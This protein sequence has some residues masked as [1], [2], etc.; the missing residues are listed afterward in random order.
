MYFCKKDSRIKNG[1]LS[2]MEEK[3]NK[4][5]EI[6]DIVRKIFAKLQ[7][8]NLTISTAESCTGGNIAH[9]IT[10]ISGASIF[11]KAG[12]VSYCNEMKEKILH[13]DKSTLDT[14]G[15]V[16]EQTAKQM[17]EGVLRLTQTDWA[18]STTGLAGPLSDGSGTDVGTVFIGIASKEKETIVRKYCIKTNREDFINRVSEEALS[19]LLSS[20]E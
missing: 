1:I 6:N 19:L 11:F 17:A 3:N 2:K 7:P 10:L 12:I 4:E 15:A 5:K 13:V 9:R 8:N 20:L 16:S 14:Y 18:I